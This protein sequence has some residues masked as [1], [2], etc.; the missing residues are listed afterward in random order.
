ME[1]RLRNVSAFT[2]IKSK[3]EKGQQLINIRYRLLS[4]KLVIVV[5]E[6]Y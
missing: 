4:Q 6:Q 3:V 5:I 1:R 2:K